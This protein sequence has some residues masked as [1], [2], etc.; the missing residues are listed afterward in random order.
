MLSAMPP[1]APFAPRTSIGLPLNTAENIA[2][3]AIAPRGRGLTGT[4]QRVVRVRL[5]RIA[6][7]KLG[8][9]IRLFYRINK[10]ARRPQRIGLD[11]E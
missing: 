11:G 6:V 9:Q 10:D 1:A 5:G 4:L 8:Q 3:M 7:G 2:P